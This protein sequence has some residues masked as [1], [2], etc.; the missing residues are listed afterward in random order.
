M[1]RKSFTMAGIAL[2]LSLLLASTVY[3]YGGGPGERWSRAPGMPPDSWSYHGGPYPAFA[4]SRRGVAV[5]TIGSLDGEAHTITVNLLGGGERIIQTTEAT[6]FV[7]LGDDTLTWIDFDALTTG[8]VLIAQGNLDEEGNFIA[9]RVAV[10]SVG[11][12]TWPYGGYSSGH[13]A[14]HGGYGGAMPYGSMPYGGPAMPRRGGRI[15]GKVIGGPIVGTITTLDA[16]TQSFTVDVVGGRAQTYVGQ[17]ITVR[18]TETT[19]FVHHDDTTISWITFDDLNVGDAVSLW[20]VPDADG[21]ITAW[22]VTTGIT[23]LH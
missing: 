9:W 21:T 15:G 13:P 2:V 17:E 10:G 23:P 19:R 7:R 1:W 16:E 22:R 5:G 8:E 18:T 12:H 6:R 3:A 11:F 14:P 4:A 20:G